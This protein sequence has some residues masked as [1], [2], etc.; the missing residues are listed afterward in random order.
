MT[1]RRPVYDPLK[2]LGDVL[3]AG[4]ALVLT[5]P[6]QLAIAISVR[7]NLGSPSLFRQRRP[8][9][10]GQPFTLVK[11]RTM[12][13]VDGDGGVGSDAERLTPFG[14]WLRSTSL[15][16]L[17]T[18]WNVVKGDMSLVGPR[19]LL[20]SYLGRYSTEQARRHEVRP[21]ITGL[22]QVRGRN[23]LRWEDKLAAD[24]EYVTHR[25]AALDVRII[26]KTVGS[27]LQRDGISSPGEAT[28]SEFMGSGHEVT[29]PCLEAS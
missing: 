8:G 4:A 21:G 12:R 5:A 22:A 27:V 17:P 13:D 7:R 15:D 1:Q 9:R 28:M 2:R 29:G 11:F 19:P 16:E 24:V 23:A 3:L 18:L 10:Y 26:A 20:M 14:I 25:S 6:I